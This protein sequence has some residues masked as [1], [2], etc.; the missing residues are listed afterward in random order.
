MPGGVSKKEIFSSSLL[1]CSRYSFIMQLV[2]D[3]GLGS[4]WLSTTN[5]SS[6][7]SG[8]ISGL[9]LIVLYSGFGAVLSSSPDSSES[10]DEL[11]LILLQSASSES[12]EMSKHSFSSA[13]AS[14]DELETSITTLKLG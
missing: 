9:S 7:F 12:A 13:T 5:P 8:C 6:S 4:L 3:W 2:I 14:A 10:S 11:S 1:T